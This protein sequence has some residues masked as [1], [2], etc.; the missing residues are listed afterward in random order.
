MRHTAAV[1]MLQAGVD[2]VSISHWLGHSSVVVTNRYTA[3]DLETKRAAIAQAGSVAK[4]TGGQAW[5][6]DESILTW[7]ESI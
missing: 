3:I 6:H 1:H 2:L 7:L 5:R 4:Q